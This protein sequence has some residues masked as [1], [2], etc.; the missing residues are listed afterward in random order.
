MHSPETHS[1]PGNMS[2]FRKLQ[3]ATAAAYSTAIL[4]SILVAVGVRSGGAAGLTGF[5][6]I[7]AFGL[8][9]AIFA[10]LSLVNVVS[11]QNDEAK[12]SF[13]G[14]CFVVDILAVIL[15]SVLA[16]ATFLLMKN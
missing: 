6:C 14:R 11:H 12:R 4:I 5:V 9:F 3:V 1:P 2:L 16:P 10:I 13:Y 7:V 15:I 8:H